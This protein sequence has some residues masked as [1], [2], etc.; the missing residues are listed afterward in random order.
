[1]GFGMA[2]RTSIVAAAV[3]QSEIGI[4]S[5]VLALGRNIAGAFGIAIFGTVLTYAMKANVL[6]IAAS[7]AIQSHDPA[8]VASFMRLI[9]LKAQ[10]DAYRTVFIVGAVIVAAGAFLAF[11]IP[12]VEMKK[13]VTVHVE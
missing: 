6:D 11:L 10:V 4:A 1:M 13:G 5:S 2:Q 12:D 3:P 7:S 8:V 9:A